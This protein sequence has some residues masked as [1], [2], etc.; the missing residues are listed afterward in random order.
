MSQ[1]AGKAGRTT[2]DEGE[3]WN[4]RC[5]TPRWVLP[6]KISGEKGFGALAKNRRK[7]HIG[8]LYT[9]I[10]SIYIIYYFFLVYRI[11]FNRNREK[12]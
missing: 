7:F 12:R 1:A 3:R 8:R 6:N 4:R 11:I 2:P 5:A 9:L 10:Y